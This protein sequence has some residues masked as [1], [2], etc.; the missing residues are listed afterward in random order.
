[1]EPLAEALVRRAEELGF[2]GVVRA[3]RAGQTV[4]AEAF[5]FAERAFR[6]PNTLA[7][8]FG[9]ASGCKAFTALAVVALVEEGR[10]SLD[11]TARSVLGTSLPEIDDRVTVEHLLAHRSGIGDYI[12]EDAGYD[13]NDYVMRVP[14]HQ[15]AT[16]ESY[17]AALEGTPQ[18]D[19]PGER[20][21]Y[22][23]SGYVVLALMAER[24]TGT[25]FHALVARTVCVPAA[26]HSTA[27]LRGDE[28]P[29]DVARGYLGPD[30]LRTNVLHLP[31]LGSGD[32]GIYSTVEDLHR[33]WTALFDGRVVPLHWVREMVRPRSDV[34]TEG[35]RYGLGFWVHRERD[36]VFL[37]GCDAGVGFRSVHDPSTAATCTVMSNT[38]N[39]AWA[40]A[41]LFDDLRWG[42]GYDGA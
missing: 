13:P 17:L 9:T 11:T 7:T 3:D 33:F 21:S 28:L 29:A 34:P 39:G 2:S 37:D 19:V 20:F 24:V 25:P 26:M 36:V 18:K 16:T 38:T 1:M 32:G 5:G 27:Y 40:L 10:L 8:R 30:G 15:L 31:V 6:S 14:V 22:N 23:N 12:D 4:I 41:A 35:R 42:G